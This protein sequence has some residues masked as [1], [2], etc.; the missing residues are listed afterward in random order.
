M[1]LSRETTSP[2]TTKLTVTAEQ[3]E[4][5][6]A[7]QATLQ[8]LSQNVSVPGFR[9]GKAPANL[10]ERQI[11]QSVLQTEFMDAVIN[12]LYVEAIDRENLR[13]VSQPEIAVTK[14]V[15]FTSLEF[16]ATVEVVGDIKLAEYKKI[17]LA[18]KPVTVTTDDVNDVLNNL[19]TRGATKEIVE[20]AAKKGDEVVIDF[21]GTDA[22]T[23]EPI[24]GAEGTDYPL[25]LGSDSFIPGFEDELIG[26][27]AGAI[28]TFDI[29]FP[30]DYGAPSLQNKKVTFAVTVRSVSAVKSAKIDDDFAASIGPFKTVTELKTDVKKQLKA[31]REQE[32]QTAYDNELLQKVA[33]KTEVVI[34]TPLIEEEMTRIEEEEKRNVVYRGQTWQ[35][36]LDAEGLTAEAHR[37]KQREGAELRVKAGLVLGE[38][39]QAEKVTVSPDELE[40]RIELLRG[41]YSDPTMQAEL[42]KPENRRDIMSRM[43]TEKTL[44]KL[45][46]FATKA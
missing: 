41:Q 4:L 24:D 15:P 42:D 21:V 22:E 39:A 30:S 18:Q 26:A 37:E 13:P 45:R 35:E 23:K 3:A 46:S 44:A 25:I 40:I 8:R 16:S 12:Q 36:H 27:K 34:P 43:L 11:N 1:K 32:A 28:T 9:K 14:F 5:D 6:Q 29:T 2:T 17:K 33:E 10:V 31:E 38:I 19:A 7:K 20:R